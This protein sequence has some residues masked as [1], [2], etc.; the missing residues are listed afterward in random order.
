M[1]IYNHRLYYSV[2]CYITYY[3]L[4]IYSIYS[5][6][7]FGVYICFVSLRINLCPFFLKI[8]NYFLYFLKKIPYNLPQNQL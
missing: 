7:F 8:C 2:I 5:I 1:I 3:M 4:Y 6:L